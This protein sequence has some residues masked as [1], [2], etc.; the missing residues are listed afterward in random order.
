MISAY[1]L[2]YEDLKKKLISGIAQNSVSRI[3]LGV[4]WKLEYAKYAKHAQSY[5]GTGDVVI[6]RQKQTY[7]VWL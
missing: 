4:A 6:S 1:N 3:T 7:I 5:K 2:I